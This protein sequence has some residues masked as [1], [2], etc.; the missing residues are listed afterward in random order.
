MGV[1]EREG[2]WRGWIY[3]SSEI[4]GGIYWRWREER[5]GPCGDELQRKGEEKV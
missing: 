5:S 2:R 3:A 1:E 4:K